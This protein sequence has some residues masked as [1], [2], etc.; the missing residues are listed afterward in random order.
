MARYPIE[1]LTG[2]FISTL[3][4][5]GL[6]LGGRYVASPGSSFGDSAPALIV[7]YFAWLVVI[8]GIGSLAGEIESDGKTGVLEA[9][10]SSSH[11]PGALFLAR[12][13]AGCCLSVATSAAVCLLVAVLLG[14]RL[15]LSPGILLPMFTL[16]VTAVGLGMAAGG[17]ALL[18]KRIGLMLAPL[19][20]LFL[21]LMWVRFENFHGWSHGVA[22]ALPSAPSSLLLR[23]AIEQPGISLPGAYLIAAF[24]SAA[25]Y[26]IAGILVFKISARVARRTGVLGMH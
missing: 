15:S 18:V 24:F 22:M 10:F 20:L 5:V 13:F 17:L 8:S 1:S 21:P 26:F 14:Q 19:Y 3:L 23:H 16:L 9:V 12:G 7:G 11:S 25:A 4:F 6:F 2:I